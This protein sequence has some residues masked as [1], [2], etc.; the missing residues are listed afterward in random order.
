MALAFVRRE[1]VACCLLVE[2]AKRFV[3]GPSCSELVGFELASCSFV[4][5]ASSFAVAVVA[6]GQ[7]LSLELAV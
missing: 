1:V 2:V 3:V 7:Q 6:E 5:S 4:D